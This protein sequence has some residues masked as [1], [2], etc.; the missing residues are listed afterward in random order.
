MSNFT[1]E[2]FICEVW[3]A[4]SSTDAEEVPHQRAT[5]TQRWARLDEITEARR[6]LDEELANLHRALGVEPRPHGPQHDS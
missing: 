6:Q 1:R 3:S 4:S 5:D 2:C